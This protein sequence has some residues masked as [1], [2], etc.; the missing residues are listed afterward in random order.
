[1]QRGQKYSGRRAIFCSRKI[2]DRVALVTFVIW[3]SHSLALSV[4]RLYTLPFTDLG[5]AAGE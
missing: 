2:P 5:S 4:R 1:V 3:S